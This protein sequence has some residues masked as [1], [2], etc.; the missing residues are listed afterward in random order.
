MRYIIYGAGAVGGTI[1]G[2][3]FQSG[4]DVLLIARGDHLHA[5]R[6]R[7]LRL[8][9]PHGDDHLPLRV[10]GAP[11]EVDFASSDVVVL[12]MKTQDTEAGLRVLEAAAPADVPVICA[13]NG[14][15]NERMASRRFTNVY[16]MVVYMPAMHLEPGEVVNPATAP[17]VLHGGRFPSGT[18]SLIE[19][20]CADLE[21]AG[22]VSEADPAIMRL[23]YRK[24]LA[25]LGSALQIVTEQPP[26]GSAWA[27]VA[28]ELRDEA[29]RC[30]AAAGIAIASA[31]EFAA[32]VERLWGHKTPS[33]LVGLSFAPPRCHPA[34]TC[35]E[36]QTGC[37]HV[38]WPP[39]REGLPGS[40]YE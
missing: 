35:A 16:G 30:Y 18:D 33:G 28:G 20:V 38:E 7:G 24:L 11:G 5:V 29:L 12:T 23:K 6:E 39:S 8:R 22:F 13:Q 31:E 10:V 19:R 26:G 37:A 25:N 36:R 4:H 21:G 17:G 2:K 1:G 27:Q 40:F 15:E 32:R 34:H 9:T 14:I 3:L